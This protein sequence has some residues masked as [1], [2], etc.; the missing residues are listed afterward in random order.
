LPGTASTFFQRKTQAHQLNLHG[1]PGPISIF[2][3]Y[4]C[5]ACSRKSPR[6]KITPTG[7]VYKAMIPVCCVKC[8]EFQ[9][10][11]ISMN[12]DEALAHLALLEN[13]VAERVYQIDQKIERKNRD[14][15]KLIKALLKHPGHA[16]LKAGIETLGGQIE[17]FEND[18]W[19]HRRLLSEDIGL[20]RSH[21]SRLRE[22]DLEEFDERS[23]KSC[24]IPFVPLWPLPW[25]SQGRKIKEFPCPRCRGQVLETILDF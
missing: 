25:K 5:Q 9:S 12:M 3:Q 7:L 21:L 19:R 23:C 2:L 11:K 18:K 15:Q 1:V 10:V 4:V 13:K 24:K 8:G 22:N 14:R 20:C 6:L 16:R 17:D